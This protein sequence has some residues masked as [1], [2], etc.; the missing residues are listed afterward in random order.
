MT[1][2]KEKVKRR[3]PRKR[4]GKFNVTEKQID[5]ALLRLTPSF[6]EKVGSTEAV[7]DELEGVS[8]LA[9][10]DFGA[11]P[12]SRRQRKL[13]RMMLYSF[14][15]GYCVGESHKARRKPARGES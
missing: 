2:E 4:I 11:A 8:R 3:T 15:I 5:Q 14:V 1:G 12:G 6:V 10:G 7:R 13:Y 9:A